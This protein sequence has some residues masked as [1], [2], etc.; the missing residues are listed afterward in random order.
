MY[1]KLVILLGYS[2]SILLYRNSVWTCTD[3][4]KY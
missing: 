1:S 2:E 4:D 3:S